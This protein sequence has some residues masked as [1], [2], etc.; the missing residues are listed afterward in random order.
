MRILAIDTSL[1]A[2]SVAAL[3][4]AGADERPLGAAGEHARVLTA[5]LIEVADRRGWGA[6]GH[7]LAALRPADVVAVIRGPGSFTGLRVGVT[8]AKALAWTTG[9]RLLGISGFQAI[10]R[11]A[12]RLAG[13][14]DTPLAI[15]Y[16]A[17]RG[18]VFAA[19]AEPVEPTAADAL[20]W[21]LT[22]P[23]LISFQ[24]WLGSLPS[25]SRVGG[26][27]ADVHRDRIL[28]HGAIECLTHE[29]CL[30]SAIDAAAIARVRANAGESDDPHTLAPDYLRP[31]YAEETRPPISGTSKP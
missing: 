21:R 7:P 24:D 1:G 9:A 14:A 4:D 8:A 19:W 13:W 22:E 17:G 16:D 20:G 18:D 12:A 25:G 29:A 10:A 28:A 26:P 30:P 27:V 5:A 6:G 23:R 3:D 15:A 11:R 31:S 2:G